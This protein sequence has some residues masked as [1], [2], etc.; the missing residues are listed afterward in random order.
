MNEQRKSWRIGVPESLPTE[1]EAPGAKSN[2]TVAVSTHAPLMD[3]ER[4]SRQVGSPAPRLQQ[5]WKHQIVMMHNIEDDI[6]SWVVF[7]SLNRSANELPLQ[8]RSTYKASSICIWKHPSAETKNMDYMR[9]L[10]FMGA[11]VLRNIISYLGYMTRE[12]IFYTNLLVR[13]RIVLTSLQPNA[14]QTAPQKF[15]HFLA[16]STVLLA[17]Q[18]IPGNLRP[19]EPHWESPSDSFTQSVLGSFLPAAAILTMQSSESKPSLQSVHPLDKNH[20]GRFTNLISILWKPILVLVVQLCL[21][22]ATVF[23]LAWTYVGN[24]PVPVALN[25]LYLKHSQSSTAVL[26]LFGT[27]LGWMTTN[28]FVYAIRLAIDISLRKETGLPLYTIFAATAVASRALLFDWNK[29]RNWNWVVISII[30]FLLFLVQT[31][32]WTT[33]ITPK[34]GLRQS[35]DTFNDFDLTTPV[36]ANGFTENNGLAAARDIAAVAGA[37]DVST[38]LNVS[39][40]LPYS[41]FALNGTSSGILPQIPTSARNGGWEKIEAVQQGLTA[42]ITCAAVSA[43][44]TSLVINEAPLPNATDATYVAVSLSC[45]ST[46]QSSSA[47]VDVNAVSYSF[48]A[49]CP[50]EGGNNP[51][52]A[53]TLYLII[54]GTGFTSRV[55]MSCSIRP[56]LQDVFVTY[57]YTGIVITETLPGTLVDVPVNTSSTVN[58]IVGALQKHLSDAQSLNTNL[59]IDPIYTIYDDY[60]RY[61][62]SEA[63]STTQA[64]LIASYIR[65]VIEDAA[66]VQVTI[67]ANNVLWGPAHT[68]LR[69]DAI[70]ISP[71]AIIIST[72]LIILFSFLLI[73]KRDLKHNMF[74]FNPMSTLHVVAACSNGNVQSTTFP[75]AD[76]DLDRDSKTVIVTLYEGRDENDG[77]RLFRAQ[78]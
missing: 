6:P 71:L 68:S 11:S 51:G 59:V 35:T 27:I 56:Q 25:N 19:G 62:P 46:N 67:Y 70:M 29:G 26:V 52:D 78:T 64:E 16:V 10:R 15:C 24:H 77:L 8:L 65:G 76:Y 22:A 4:T 23:F 33:I 73:Q 31:S 57:N 45:G 50:Q 49:T 7:C 5:L 34:P 74:A 47:V 54:G 21:L 3:T 38:A 20:R 48:F 63:D 28:H 72:I 61:M 53:I 66:T 18:S 17:D 42:N 36:L 32:A 13:K 9:M 69:I 40:L 1:H 41:D 14:C 58:S 44:D 2:Q 55:L 30:Y 37:I 60:E 75:Q 12:R 43:S 39:R